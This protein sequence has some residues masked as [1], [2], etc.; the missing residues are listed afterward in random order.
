MPV[1]VQKDLQKPI[2]VVH[3]NYKVAHMGNTGKSKEKCSGG[4]IWTTRE[5]TED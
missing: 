1:G 3:Q 5:K 2:A 4:R